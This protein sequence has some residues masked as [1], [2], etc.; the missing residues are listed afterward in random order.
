MS[1]AGSFNRRPFCSPN[2]PIAG[3]LAGRSKSKRK[4][5]GKRA[6]RSKF[7]FVFA[8]VPG[9]RSGA[10]FGSVVSPSAVSRFALPWIVFPVPS[11]SAVVSASGISPE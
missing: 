8:N 10:P 9:R 4:T 2:C 3:L 6:T 1:I 7:L 11:V 5:S